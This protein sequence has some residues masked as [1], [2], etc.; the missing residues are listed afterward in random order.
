MQQDIYIGD[1]EDAF[2]Q[3]KRITWLLFAYQPKGITLPDIT[4]GQIYQ[5]EVEVYGTVRGPANWRE[6]AVAEITKLG[7]RQAKLDA[8]L[9][10]LQPEGIATAMPEEQPQLPLDAGFDLD[11]RRTGRTRVVPRSL[12]IDVGLLARRG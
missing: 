7:Y 1:M 4:P 6:T 5:L 10:D 8:C 11:R 3:G 2:Q 9:F 12:P